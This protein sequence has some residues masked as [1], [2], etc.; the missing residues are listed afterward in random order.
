[1]KKCFWTVLLTVLGAI[2]GCRVIMPAPEY[3]MPHAR[4]KLTGTTLDDQTGTPLRGILVRLAPYSP[5]V[6]SDSSGT[7]SLD[8]N[9]F[10]CGAPC[11][12]TST[13]V[14]GPENGGV[15]DSL[16]VTIAPRHTDGG[17]GHWDLG[18]YEQDGIVFRLHKITGR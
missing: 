16:T 3:G 18:T 9:G 17:D 13:D 1:M 8:V 10:L 12:M 11:T 7:W 2:T 4:Y 15:F 6:H 14:D 5:G